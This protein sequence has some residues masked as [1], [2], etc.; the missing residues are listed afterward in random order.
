M[1]SIEGKDCMVQ[2][3]LSATGREDQINELYTLREQQIK[4]T[5]QT[6]NPTIEAKNL[7]ALFQA[8]G[9]NI[10]IQQITIASIAELAGL[11][12][13][14]HDVFVGLPKDIDSPP[15]IVHVAQQGNNGFTSNQQFLPDGILIIH[16]MQQGNIQVFINLGEAM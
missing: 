1:S 16:L 11:L 13:E 8:L 15:H 3:V 6:L 4:A 7:A 9:K 2:A 14:G 10:N 12:Q 5:G